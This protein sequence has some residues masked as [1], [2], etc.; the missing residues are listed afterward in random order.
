MREVP[1]SDEPRRT[2]RAR[3]SAP[4]ID[5]FEVLDAQPFGVCCVDET[6]SVSYANGAWRRAAGL[7]AEPTAGR[8]LW[9]LFPGLDEA[10]GALLRDT[11]ADGTSRTARVVLDVR[12]TAACFA[13]RASRIGTGL[14][15][16]F[17]D[18]TL[19]DRL[20]RDRAAH[21][22]MLSERYEENAD[23]RERVQVAAMAKSAFLAAVSHELRTPLTTLT[24]YGELLADEIVGPL[25]EPQHEVIERMRT[26]THELTTMVDE[27]LAF[28]NLEFGR[29][30]VHRERVGIGD[31]LA[32]AL[33]ETETAARRK[34]L[35]CRCELPEELPAIHT[36][37]DKGRRIL[38][39]LAANAIKFT[40]AGEVLF[41]ACR[42]GNG[43]R[44][45][46]RDTGIGI[47]PEDQGRLFQPFS[48]LDQGL[49]RTHGGTGLGLYVSQRL[50]RLIG[51]RLELVSQPGKG[52]EFSVVFPDGA[53]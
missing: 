10:C 15:L 5:P 37:L 2:S 51:A 21:E 36:D 31:L 53:G 1:R 46:V 49:T 43:V 47:A 11:V 34:G 39:N 20:E 24:G 42:E 6:W 50:A 7:R 33:A 12:G 45:T 3:V 18:A 4:V 28:S 25:T 48:Q 30:S 9:E 29:E 22:R 16:T 41:V 44:I 38:H 27:L 40:D 52:S 23:L 14:T 17:E 26:V 32:P 8:T 35:R 13:V 19:L